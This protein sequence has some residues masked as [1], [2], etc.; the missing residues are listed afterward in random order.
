MICSF[1][2]DRDCFTLVRPTEEEKD[3][4]KLNTLSDEEM[5]PEFQNQMKLLR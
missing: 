2:K 5:R 3:L 4:Q 1:F